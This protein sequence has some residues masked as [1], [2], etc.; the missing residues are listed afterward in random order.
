M[1]KM[2]NLLIAAWCH[3]YQQE[4]NPATDRFYRKLSNRAFSRIFFHEIKKC[5]WDSS[6]KAVTSP[7][8]QSKISAIKDFEQQDWDKFLAQ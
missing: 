6:L 4:T 7:S 5:S 1:A 8:A 3:F 2:M